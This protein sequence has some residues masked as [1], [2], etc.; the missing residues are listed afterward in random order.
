MIADALQETAKIHPTL[1]TVLGLCIVAIAVLLAWTLLALPVSILYHAC[2]RLLERT[3]NAL[4]KSASSILAL[5]KSFLAEISRSSTEFHERRKLRFIF[6]RS[7]LDVRR[8]FTDLKSDLSGLKEK[9][10]STQIQ[11]DASTTNLVRSIERTNTTSLIPEKIDFPDP[12]RFIEEVSSGRRAAI[13][14]AFGAVLSIGLISINT[15]MLNEFFSSFISI[16]IFGISAS[17]VLSGFFSFAE[18][19]TGVFLYFNDV[20]ASEK[21][22]RYAVSQIALCLCI[23]AFMGVESFFYTVLSGQM[24]RQIL[25]D[26]FAPQAPP[27]WLKYWLTPFGF[28][29][30]ALLSYSGHLTMSG[31]DQI[32]QN[33]IAREFRRKMARYQDY[34]RS[35]G[36]RLEDLRQRATGVQTAVAIL[37]DEMIGSKGQPPLISTR[38]SETISRFEKAVDSA[39][40]ARR[41]IYAEASHGEILNQLSVHVILAVGCLLVITVYAWTASVFLSAGALGSVLSGWAPVIAL[42]EAT[43]LLGAAYFLKAPAHLV[44]V[45]EEFEFISHT[46]T[47]LRIVGPMLAVVALVAFNAFLTLSHATSENFWCFALLLGCMAYFFYV[48]HNLPLLASVLWLCAISLLRT[49]GLVLCA[50]SAGVLGGAAVIFRLIAALLFILGFPVLLLAKRWNFGP[51][52]AGNIPGKPRPEPVH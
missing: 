13:K 27:D 48:G 28:V 12:P 31:A 37:R 24:D 14:L 10:A 30:V 43:I 9:V 51:A 17:F 40:E 49:L 15:M 8:R 52:T 19:A 36:D 16:Y 41:E 33:S 11:V 23:L 5:G 26:F 47:W 50:V 7:E 6:D 45:G 25:T 44:A 20:S 46:I 22:L 34:A 42:A 21:G 35:V 39:T 4:L 29:V 38:I 32:A 1:P 18:L 2:H 3:S